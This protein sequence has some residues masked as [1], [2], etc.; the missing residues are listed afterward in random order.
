M[1]KSKNFSEDHFILFYFSAYLAKQFRDAVI[2]EVAAGRMKVVCNGVSSQILP[3]LNDATVRRFH[4]GP[5][6]PHPVA[7]FEVTERNLVNN[8]FE[9]HFLIQ[10]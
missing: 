7:S 9:K 5:V 10:I 4:R 8:I 2:A 3:G 6:G 1:T